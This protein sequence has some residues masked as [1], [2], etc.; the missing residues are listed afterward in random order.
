[1]VK[2]TEVCLINNAAGIFIKISFTN[3]LIANFTLKD[4]IHPLLMIEEKSKS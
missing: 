2:I 3:F 4:F 1:M